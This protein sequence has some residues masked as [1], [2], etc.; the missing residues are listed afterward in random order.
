M[1]LGASRHRGTSAR[2][3]LPADTLPA[4]TSHCLSPA[5]RSVTLT[6]LGRCG[7]H[8]PGQKKR[9]TASPGAAAGQATASRTPSSP[10]PVRRAG[11]TGA[12][13][14]VT[15]SRPKQNKTGEEEARFRKTSADELAM[16]TLPSAW[17]FVWR[18]LA[19]AISALALLRVSVGVAAWR[20]AECLERTKYEVIRKVGRGIEIRCV[21]CNA[22][23]PLHARRGA[24]WTVGSNRVYHIKLQSLARARSRL[25]MTG[26]PASCSAQA[27]RALS[28]GRDDC[29][30]GWGLG[31][32]GQQ[33]GL[34]H[35]GKVYLWRQQRG[36]QDEDDR[37]GH[38]LGI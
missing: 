8:T 17:R 36:G 23:A 4:D 14:C 30:S 21:Q 15:R 34:P 32:A 5:C 18:A 9:Q 22:W 11:V 29:P 3:A 35:C 2:A 33:P 37:P 25:Q 16:L 1:R 13:P 6:S 12:A 10:A 27:V 26:L 31:G 19:V 7:V 20:A 38:H 28:G 24:E